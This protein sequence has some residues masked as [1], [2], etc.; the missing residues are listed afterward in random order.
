[1]TSREIDSISQKL[2]QFEE[3]QEL[4]KLIRSA[5]KQGIDYYW[6]RMREGDAWFQLKKYSRAIDSY[7][8]ARKM[9]RTE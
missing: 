1:M 5:R 7:S 4:T 8:A 2:Y 3:W 6:L 9:N